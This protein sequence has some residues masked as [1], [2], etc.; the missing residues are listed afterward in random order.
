[1]YDAQGFAV[2]NDLK[3]YAISG[4]DAQCNGDGSID[5]DLGKSPGPGL[6]TNWL[7]G[8][9]VTGDGEKIVG[10]TPPMRLY[11][12]G[13]AIIQGVWESPPLALLK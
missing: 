7:P 13:L 4:S 3:R 2:P 9:S 12:P 10:F 5:L 6:E 8:L 11:A 1:M